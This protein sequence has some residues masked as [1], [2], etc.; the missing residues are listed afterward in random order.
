M[1]PKKSKGNF[2]MRAALRARAVCRLDR[3]YRLIITLMKSR[4]VRLGVVTLLLLLAVPAVTYAQHTSP[5][6]RVDEIFIGGGGELDACSDE[7]CADQSIGGTA[8]GGTSSE[9]FQTDGGFGTPGEPFIE[10]SVSNY[11][12]DLGVLNT[13]G[14]AAASANFRVINYLTDG[15]VVKIY[16]AT[17]TNSSGAQHALTALNSPSLSQPGTEQFGINL[18]ANSNPGIGANPSLS[19]DETFS[20]GEA[21]PGYNTEDHFK[22]V[23]GDIIAQSERDSGETGYTISIIANISNATPGGQYKTVLVVQAIATF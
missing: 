8:V 9:N 12:I 5:N 3:R 4:I 2:G 16:G 11:L 13:S 19:P 10:V 1:A 18:V 7:Y 14:T 17:P 23:S 21:A 15:Y 20:F 6:F 22:F